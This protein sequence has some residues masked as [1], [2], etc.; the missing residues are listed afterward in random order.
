MA[1]NRAYWRGLDERFGLLPH[2]MKATL[3][4][5]VWL[6]A[7]SVGEA[8]A[9][10]P[11]VRRLRERMPDAAV[12][13]STTTLAGRA[14]CEQKLGGLADG[15]FYAPLDYPFAVRRVLRRLRPAVVAVM[16][17]EI[18]P[19]LLRE[20]RRAGA[21]VVIVN[22]RIS[23]RALPRYRNL[24][25]FFRHALEQVDRVLAQDGT[26]AERYRALGA[27]RVE[28]AGNLKYDFD[29]SATKMPEDIRDFLERLRAEP[30]WVA[31]STMPPAE[32]G[33]PDEDDAVLDAFERLARR[34]RRMLLILA[35]RRPERFDTAAEKLRARGLRFVRRTE[36]GAGT[37]VEP[38][39]VLLLDSIGELSSL[40]GAATAV[41]MGGTLVQRGGHNILEPAAHG[42]VVAA[43]PHLEN[44]AEIA[45]DFRR[46][47]GMISV[48]TAE[49]LPAALERIFADAGLRA[50]MGARARALAAA[51]RGATQ[52]ALEAIAELREAALPRPADPDPPARLWLAGMAAHRAV[53]G[54]WKDEPERPVISVGNLAMGG[55]G[56]TPMVRW[57]CR[58]LAARGLRPAV[59]TRGYGR[60]ERAPVAALPGESL[61]V[62]ATGEEAQMVLGDGFAAVAVGADRAAARRLLEEGRGYRPDVYVLD[63]GFQHW[64]MRRELDIV[65]VDALD[66]FR[67]GVFP[68][69]RLR[70]PFSALER[71][72]AIVITRA[73]PG[74]TYAG[75]VEE[76]RRHNRQAPLFFARFAAERPRLPE[77][78]RPGAFCGIG[79]PEG[80]R[81]TLAELGIEPAFFRAFPDHWRHGKQEIEEMFRLA[82]VLLT[83]EKDLWNLPAELRG[84]PAIVAVPVRLELERP[85][86]LLRLVLEAAAA[87][88]GGRVR[89]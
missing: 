68:R 8:M 60:S 37:A 56:K 5:A 64:A 48:E 73:E 61:P 35:P 81:R 69:G 14:L 78:V 4:G 82:P 43:G 41:F 75:L 47:G 85:E 72:D 71:A 21:R 62:E 15:I 39:A 3:P 51:R 45:E 89:G 23:D 76:I 42:A 26:A 52:R 77:G 20:A 7:V 25:W 32:A 49:E 30:V 59:L 66:P 65:L 53:A 10:G 70:E 11:L 84:H 58:E 50:G 27:P 2:S 88:S 18:W 44:F 34:W 57:L 29:P 67:G 54:L 55:T 80:F 87:W 83:T 9:A 40:F 13:V 36:L 19:N 22:G 63:D 12:Y 38:P 46:N 17:T 1:R 16:E 86:E 28:I 24:A 79:Q 6:H 33:D 74:R 31:A